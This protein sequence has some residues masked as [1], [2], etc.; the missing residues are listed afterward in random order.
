MEQGGDNPMESEKEFRIRV[1]TF[2][3]SWIGCKD[4]LTIACSH[5][6][7]IPVAIEYMVELQTDLKKGGWTEFTITDGKPTLKYLIQKMV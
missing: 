5:G 1:K 3:E 6:D 4:D 2:C 7:W